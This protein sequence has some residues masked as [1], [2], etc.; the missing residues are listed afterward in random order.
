MRL[1]YR[2][3]LP[4]AAATVFGLSAVVFADPDDRRPLERVKGWH[5]CEKISFD[6]LRD[7]VPACT[8]LIEDGSLGATGLIEVF[9]ARAHAY[10]FAMT[11]RGD[12][13]ASEE[14]LWQRVLNDTD[15]ALALAREL[16]PPQPEL[17]EKVLE[18][19]GDARG[20]TSDLLGALS[21][22]TKALATAG[23]TAAFLLG[24][25][26]RVY[27][28]MGRYREAVADI[29]AAIQIAPESG[30]CN[31]HNWIFQ[32]GEMH[33]AAGNIEAAIVDYR[34]TLKTDASHI[35]AR[36]ALDR[37]SK[38]KAQQTPRGPGIRR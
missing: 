22:Y 25:R 29:S 2:V 23:D 14:E 10:I 3:I 19:R 36:Q 21:D 37:L 18:K 11:Y 12:D 30:R 26:A 15:R 6:P 28:A 32:R 8:R 16:D 9:L 34:N 1:R 35:C 27:A 31:L 20:M 33:E 5:T 24:S 7:T 17:V 38:E 13:D 4:L